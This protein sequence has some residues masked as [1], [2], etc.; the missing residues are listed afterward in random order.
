M[1][2]T[3]PDDPDTIAIKRAEIVVSHRYE[4]ILVGSTAKNL[5]FVLLDRRVSQPTP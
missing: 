1:R 4:W 5:K 2:A 3:L